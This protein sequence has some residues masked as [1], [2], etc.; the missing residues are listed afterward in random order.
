MVLTSKK[1]K[2]QRKYNTP[3]LRGVPL[4]WRKRNNMADEATGTYLSYNM[5]LS[6]RIKIQLDKAYKLGKRT[7]SAW[8]KS[9]FKRKLEPELYAILSHFSVAIFDNKE[10][11]LTY[12]PIAREKWLKDYIKEYIK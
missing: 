2:R 1:R 12:D 6:E 5:G 4:Y 9:N 11:E 10:T 3:S 8:W 7:S